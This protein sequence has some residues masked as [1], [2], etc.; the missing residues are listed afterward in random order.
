MTARMETA[1]QRAPQIQIGRRGQ[2]REIAGPP[3]A[4][5]RARTVPLTT[6]IARLLRHPAARG[7][8]RM[9]VTRTETARMSHRH[10]RV[11]RVTRMH[12]RTPIVEAD[13]RTKLRPG[14]TPHRLAATRRRR[15]LIPRPPIRR[16]RALTLRRPTL[17]R[18]VPTPRL[19]AVTEEEEARVT[20]EVVEVTLTAEAVVGDRMAVARTEAVRTD[21]NSSEKKPA[22]NFGAGIFVLTRSVRTQRYA[23]NS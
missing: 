6:A 4:E 19:A 2:V 3:R 11:R 21:A 1:R 9:A 8:T 13:A 12:R 16:L 20:A 10:A 7:G 22:P 15:A 5:N 18:R 17:R 23:H 14:L